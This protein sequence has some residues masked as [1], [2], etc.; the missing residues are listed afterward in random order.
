MLGED[1]TKGVEL[2]A[3]GGGVCVCVPCPSLP[4]AERQAKWILLILAISSSVSLNSSSKETDYCL[5]KQKVTA[6]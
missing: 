4:R 1:A 2:G 5:S 6:L 3:R